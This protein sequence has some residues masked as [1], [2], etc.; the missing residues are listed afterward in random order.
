MQQLAVYENTTELIKSK[1]RSCSQAFGVHLPRFKQKA[2]NFTTAY[3][4]AQDQQKVEKKVI[5]NL[6]K[7]VQTTVTPLVLAQI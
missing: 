6:T 2:A 1:G 7:I 3:M 4:T 5:Q